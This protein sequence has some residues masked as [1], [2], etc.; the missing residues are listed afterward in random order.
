MF[1][2][3]R[4]EL[5]DGLRQSAFHLDFIDPSLHTKSKNLN[6]SIT[7]SSGN[8]D[9]LAERLEDNYLSQ[10]NAENPLDF[11][12][13]W[14]ARG[15][16]ARFRLLEHYSRHASTPQADT[17]RDLA[18]NYALDIL[19]CDTQLMTSSLTQGY[20]WF[21]AFHS[22]FPAYIHILQDLRKRPLEKRTDRTWDAL[23]DNHAARTGGV[24]CKDRPFFV[25][26]SRLVLQAWDAREA[27]LKERSQFGLPCQ[28][29]PRIVVEIRM[30]IMLLTTSCRAVDRAVENAAP[31][32]G[33]TKPHQQQQP[34]GLGEQSEFLRAS[35]DFSTQIPVSMEFGGPSVGRG[36]SIWNQQMEYSEQSVPPVVPPVDANMED[37]DWTTIDWNSMQ[38]YK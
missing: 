29:L 8:I 16:L 10:C 6:P 5:A 32:D 31:C 37:F 35:D 24:E 7:Q 17:I 36:T 9:A 21:A 27:A 14:T 13:L 2:V 1:A 3:V 30:Q 23:S 4:S 15:H 18:V 11:I 22:P 33:Q 38:G 28:E 25:V 20:T 34:A 19:S 26:F 12:T